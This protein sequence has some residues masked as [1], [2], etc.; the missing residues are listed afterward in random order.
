MTHSRLYLY[1]L[2]SKQFSCLSKPRETGD[3]KNPNYYYIFVFNELFFRQPT[4]CGTLDGCFPLS[5]YWIENTGV[6][7][8][9]GNVLI[10]NF[11]VKFF[12]LIMLNGKL[13]CTYILTYQNFAR[14]KIIQ[15]K[16]IDESTLY[17]HSSSEPSIKAKPQKKSTDSLS[18]SLF[19]ICYFDD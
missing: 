7:E 11:Q 8:E 6:T 9:N 12:V 13:I 14:K 3:K 15:W 4:N 10:S 17:F 16:S 19:R 2:Q 18:V 5:Y 1:S